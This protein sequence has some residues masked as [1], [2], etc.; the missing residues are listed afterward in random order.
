MIASVP[1]SRALWWQRPFR[2]A[3]GVLR[4][5]AW[6]VAGVNTSRRRRV[7]TLLMLVFG[8]GA[9]YGGVMGGFAGV[10]PDRWLQ[11]TY[12]AVKVP[13][14]LLA[15]F[16][17]GLPSYYVVHALLGLSRDFGDAVRALL[18]TQAGLTVILASFAPV[19][20]L[21]Y[22][23]VPDYNLALLFNAAMFG[24][25]SLSAQVMLRRFYRPLIARDPRHRT[26]LRVWL[27]IYAFIGVQMGWTLRPFI[28]QPDIPTAFFRQDAIGNA[29]EA[30]WNI[31][32]RVLSG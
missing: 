25:A 12:S 19:T 7:A 18:A 1:P 6:A 28:G 27:G 8:F 10:T 15:T 21:W 24:L 2:H 5:A 14:L 30:V 32:V 9:L 4:G 22:L 31:V 16:A 13:L 26:L 11:M 23:S 20:A 29:Y 3:D 17:L